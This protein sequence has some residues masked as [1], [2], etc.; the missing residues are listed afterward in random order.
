MM[1]KSRAYIIIAC[2]IV[3]AAA[4]IIIIKHN[5]N[6]ADKKDYVKVGIEEAFDVS[7]LEGKEYDNLKFPEH[8]SINKPEAVYTGE[9]YC[10]DYTM[11]NEAGYEKIFKQVL[12][13]AGEENTYSEKYVINSDEYYPRGAMYE[14]GDN[15]M[16]V[17]CTGFFTACIGTDKYNLE[18]NEIIAV[19]DLNSA[20][21][22]VEYELIYGKLSIKEAEKLANENA[23]YYMRLLGYEVSYKASRIEVMRNTD[24]QIFYYVRF[25]CV[26]KGAPIIDVM[27]QHPSEDEREY[28]GAWGGECCIIGTGAKNVKNVTYNDV[29]LPYGEMHGEETIISVGDAAAMLNRKL[30]GQ[31]KYEIQSV[32]LEY[33]MSIKSTLPGDGEDNVHRWNEDAEGWFSYDLAD[34]RPCWAFHI[35]LEY[36]KEIVGYV[37]CTTG[38]I[39]FVYNQ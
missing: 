34:A 4:A 15:Y 13:D 23:Q 16:S 31:K 27:R 35:D 19:Y 3:V 28:N 24:N 32:D 14:E 8:I 17:G 21:E 9:S 29:V 18:Q 38:E 30:S 11:A 12:R 2:V 36:R 10:P 26:F 39:V 33:M 25:Q 22:D 37:D 1:K 5:Q 20:Y 6:K 7:E